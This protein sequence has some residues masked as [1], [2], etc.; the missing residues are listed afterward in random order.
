MRKFDHSLSTF[1]H[2]ATLANEKN[3][4]D[5]RNQFTIFVADLKKELSHSVT[6]LDQSTKSQEI[7]HNSLISAVRSLVN[8]NEHL[9]TS[10]SDFIN[11]I[12]RIDFPARLDKI[13]NSVA[14]M[15]IGIQNTQTTVATLDRELKDKMERLA[16]D[17]GTQI[18]GAQT[19]LQVELTKISKQNLILK[20]LLWLSIVLSVSLGVAFIFLR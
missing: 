20:I 13:D 3:L 9:I 11:V 15:N 14:G 10:N 1:H 6:T 7:S 2:E 19:S 8:S 18:V 12:G 5:L 17:L 16:I 4:N